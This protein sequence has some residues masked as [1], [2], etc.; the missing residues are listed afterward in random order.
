MLSTWSRD[1][2]RGTL[3]HIPG[4]VDVGVYGGIYLNLD[5]SFKLILFPNIRGIL[6]THSKKI[7]ST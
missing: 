4:L 2:A 6:V 3:L 7:G 1:F 5:A